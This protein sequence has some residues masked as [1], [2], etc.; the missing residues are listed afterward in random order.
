VVTVPI[1]AGDVLLY[2]GHGLFAML[3][4]LKTWQFLWSPG[5][6]LVWTRDRDL[7]KSGAA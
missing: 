6:E 1:L 4:R 5:L 7:A 2:E 3:I